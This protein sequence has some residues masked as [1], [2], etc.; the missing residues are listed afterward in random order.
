MKDY[1]QTLRYCEMLNQIRK[2]LPKELR[3]KMS[4]PSASTYKE[5]ESKK[6]DPEIVNKI[7]AIKVLS[8]SDKK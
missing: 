1:P 6:M 3:E 5:I 2:M 7:I 8:N 4:K